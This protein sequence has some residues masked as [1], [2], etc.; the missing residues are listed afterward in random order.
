MLPSNLKQLKDIVMQYTDV[1][2]LTK[3]KIDDKFPTV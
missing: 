2:S 1:L 3:T